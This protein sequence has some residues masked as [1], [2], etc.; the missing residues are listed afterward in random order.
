MFISHAELKYCQK[1]RIASI[2]TVFKTHDKSGEFCYKQYQ[3]AS[4]N[5]DF[6][7]SLCKGTKM[8]NEFTCIKHLLFPFCKF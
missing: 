5:T 1:N 7:Q 3:R 8:K 6:T 2:H 4:P